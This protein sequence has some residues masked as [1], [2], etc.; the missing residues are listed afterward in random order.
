M[1]RHKAFATGEA[2]PVTGVY[3][4]IH[5][6]HRLPHK[7]VILKDHHFPRCAKCQQNVL[8]DLIH[9]MPDLY[10]HSIYQI[11]ELPA[12]DDEAAATT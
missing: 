9:A 5:R 1:E 2:V 8:F 6:A 11:Y 12:T 3:R 10:Q 4:V 7:V